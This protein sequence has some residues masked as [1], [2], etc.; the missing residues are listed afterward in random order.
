MKQT[1]DQYYT[2]SADAKRCTELVQSMYDFST[3]DIILE[4]S[5]GSGAFIAFLP[6]DK[7]VAL[8]IDPKHELVQEQD[9]LTY[10][11]PKGSKVLVIGNPPFGRRAKL[12]KDFI[13]RAAKFSDVIAFIL[14]AIFMKPGFTNSLAPFLHLVHEEENIDSFELPNGSIHK[15][16]CCFQIW[17]KKSV[18]REKVVLKDSH[19]D[20]SVLH[21]HLSRT[22]PEQLEVLR[23]SSDFCIGQVTGKVTNL[24][25]TER[26]SQY[27]VK[28]NTETKVV[29]QI[30]EKEKLTQP[31]VYNMGAVSFSRAD[32]VSIYESRMSAFK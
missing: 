19:K 18:K 16:N 8:D 5:A 31:K 11:P 20:F 17:E 4:P 28:D 30:F 23:T 22:S 7:L 21:A 32:L 25:T 12:A 1:L 2:I 10:T 3:F 27:F 15:V 6:K 24:E 14:P 13:N 9:F 26:G 29:R